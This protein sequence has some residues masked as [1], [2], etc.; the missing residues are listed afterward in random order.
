MKFRNRLNLFFTVA[1]MALTGG[2]FAQTEPPAELLTLD[3]SNLMTLDETVDG[4]YEGWAIIEGAPVSTGVFN[5]NENGRPVDTDGNVI[6]IFQTGVDLSGA[7]SI[8]ISIEP[9]MDSDPAPS[10]L[11]ILSGDV[12]DGMAHL[13]PAIPGQD[14]L[15]TASGC[16]ILATPSDNEMAPEND[17]QGVWFLA[18]P[19]PMPG[20]MNLPPLGDKWTYEGWAVDMSSGSPMPYSTGTFTG[21]EGADSDAA[22]CM[23][24][25]PA[26][27]GQ[28]F[29]EYHCGPVLDLDSGQFALVI[30]IEPVPDNSPTPF[31]FK[32]LAGMVPTEALNGG[33]MLEN[34]TAGTFPGGVATI[35]K[36]VATEQARWGGLKAL[37]R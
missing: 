25:G 4:L 12:M 20:L 6:H 19:G 11:I 34:Q 3:F 10:G 5:V 16:Y 36:T 15:E 2:A 24:G 29:T 30:S 8:K 32:P 31:Q 26:F 18:M 28:D 9:D 23:G 14:M 21:G 22:G 1:L 35:T 7:S 17:D 13:H 33:G 27:P 37:F